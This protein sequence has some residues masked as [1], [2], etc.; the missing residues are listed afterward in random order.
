MVRDFFVIRTINENCLFFLFSVSKKFLLLPKNVKKSFV[1][2]S[3]KTK[4][5]DRENYKN[6]REKELG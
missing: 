1:R 5:F 2:K 6:V 4:H 3:K